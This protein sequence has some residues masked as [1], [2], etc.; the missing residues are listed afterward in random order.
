MSLV[1]VII[2]YYRK[3]H[4]ILRTLKSVINQTYENLEIIIIY[5]DTEKN[6]L[7]LIKKMISMDKRI[8]LIINKKNIGAGKS[9]N[10][11]IKISKG[12]YIAFIDADDIWLKNKTKL[13]LAHMKKRKLDFTHTNYSIINKKNKQLSNRAARDFMDVKDL[14]TS[15]DIGLSTVMIRKNILSSNSFSGLKT[16]EDFVLWLKLLSKN[17]KIYGINKNLVFWNKNFNS[18]SSSTIQKLLD[19]YR[20]Y[21]SHM[22]YNFLKSF[23]Y[24]LC[25][26]FNY[27][28]K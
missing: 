24:L 16:K 8:K 11:G 6:D 26:S 25:L 27:L 1:S 18:L 7:K 4:Y 28:K 12:S 10:K 14:I 22:N 15:C 13:Q 20:V 21:N 9:R 19:G 3:K 23:Y 2:P 5:D 17:I